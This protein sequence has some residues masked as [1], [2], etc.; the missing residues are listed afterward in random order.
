MRDIDGFLKLET[1]DGETFSLEDRDNPVYYIS[2]NVP[3]P[4]RFLKMRVGDLEKVKE[5]FRHKAF[6]KVCD[7]LLIDIENRFV[8]L[9][10][11]KKT[12]RVKEFLRAVLQ[13]MSTYMKFMMI[14]HLFEDSTDY[15]ITLLIASENVRP[16]NGEVESLEFNDGRRRS[17]LD[18]PDY[19]DTY[20]LFQQLQEEGRIDFDSFPFYTQD[21]KRLDR[22]IENF[23][24]NEIFRRRE[25]TLYF[26]RVEN[27]SSISISQILEGV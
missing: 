21:F 5:V 16:V 7:A 6:T 25:V 1:L 13:L 2:L 27:G 14:L 20:G 4:G 24:I 3:N 19:C 15:A 12:L 23:R 9:V 18:S 11:L 26:K 17:F 8:I 22:E 10:E